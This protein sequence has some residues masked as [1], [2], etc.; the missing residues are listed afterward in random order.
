MSKDLV[1]VVDDELDNRVMMRYFL[2]SWGYD[3]EL[4]VNGD[5]ALKRVAARRPALVLLDLEMPVM[6]GFETCHRLK[7]D[8]KTEAI[9][10]IMFT[11]LES[12]SDKVRGIRR[13][14]DD[15]VVKTVDPEEIQA[16]IEM[17][18]RRSRRYEAAPEK[19]PTEAVL[20]GSLEEKSFPE[21]FQLALA[22]GQSGTLLLKSGDKDGRV[23]LNDGIVS[24]AEAGSLRGEDAFYE[25]AHWGRGNFSYLVGL[26]SKEQTIRKSATTLLMEATRRVDEWNLISSKIPSFDAAPHRIAVAAPEPLRITRS[27]WRVASLAD[28]RK[29]IREIASELETDLYEVGRSVFGMITAGALSLEPDRTER[30]SFFDAVP[31]LK[32]DLR[33]EEPQELSAASWKLLAAID[34]KRDLG[35]ITHIVGLVPR[36]L[37]E[38]L[39]DLAERGFVKV[40]MPPRSRGESSFSKENGKSAEPAKVEDFT[41]RIRVIGL[42]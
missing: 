4:A 11:G 26:L 33:G 35:A 40:N 30:D 13:G 6:D 28:G 3:V 29:T 19:E 17:I 32:P 37:A 2:E 12:T 5:E 21:A 25:L 7:D 9:P 8:P 27:D 1:L 31:E 24:H 16:R 41:P 22:Y 15:Y 39:K 14:A 18:L 23:Y 34:G 36:R 42:D 38:L 10:V 20:S